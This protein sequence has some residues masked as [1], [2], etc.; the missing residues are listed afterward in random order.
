MDGQQKRIELILARSL[1]SSLSTPAYLMDLEGTLVYYNEAA[2]QLVGVSFEE[3]GPLGREE[4]GPAFA[5][6]DERGERISFDEHPLITAIREGKAGHYAQRI[7]SADGAEHEVEI[8]AV[9]LLGP[10]GFEGAMVFFW[11]AGQRA[12]GRGT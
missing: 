11:P 12:A 7:R 5:P 10:G 6:F 3:T 1:L 4:W 9:P 2:E 8:S